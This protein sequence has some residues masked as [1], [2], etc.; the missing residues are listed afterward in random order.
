MLVKILT[1]VDRLLI[2]KCKTLVLLWEITCFKH[3]L[4]GSEILGDMYWIMMIVT[5][6]W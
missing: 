4:L 5:G 2:A 1:K 6:C 3:C